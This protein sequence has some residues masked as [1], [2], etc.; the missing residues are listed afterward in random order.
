MDNANN[1]KIH[2]PVDDIWDFY[3]DNKKAL[4][5]QLVELASCDKTVIYL[6]ENN[7]HPQL[8]VEIDGVECGTTTALSSLELLAWTEQ[9]YIDYILYPEVAD[10][11]PDVIPDAMDEAIE[12]DDEL[13]CAMDDFL[14]VLIDKDTYRGIFE[15]EGFEPHR[16]VLADICAML[17][18]RYG[19]EVNWPIVDNWE[20]T[21]I[22]EFLNG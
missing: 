22:D 12:R 1:A 14:R 7:D 21:S 15:A 2:V 19:L 20:P 10:D 9:L 4:S 18:E 8:V 3:E 16:V 5:T 6:T 17:E 11:E 13:V